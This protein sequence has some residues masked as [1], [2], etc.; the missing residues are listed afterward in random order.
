MK[1]SVL[2]L[3]T[4]VL[5]LPTLAWAQ[6][7]P[8]PV[9]LSTSAMLVLLGCTIVSYGIRRF[10]PQAGFFHSQLGA[11]VLAGVAVAASAIA[12][13]VEGVGLHGVAIEQAVIAAL[14]SLVATSNPSVPL[15]QAP[16]LSPKSVSSQAAGLAGLALLLLSAFAMNG[17]AIPQ[18]IPTNLDGGAYDASTN[19]A[20]YTAAFENCLQNQGISDATGVGAQIFNIL[21]TGGTS[22]SQ[23]EASIE[24]ALVTLSGSTA[25]LVA[26]C[27][28]NAFDAIEPVLANAKPSPSQAAIRLFRA[29]HL[30]K[31][32]V[33]HASAGG[34]VL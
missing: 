25:I 17:C 20:A 27:A 3:A 31:P 24:K 4:L 23:I 21:A 8:L 18:P 7:G 19:S 28:V 9:T 1:R 13:T 32:T 6:Q 29:R 2:F 12:S 34:G 26:T 16:P 14:M 11:L 10:S 15:G 22:A 33:H 5:L 30:T